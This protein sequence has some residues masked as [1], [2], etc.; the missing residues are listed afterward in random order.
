MFTI[1][2][3]LKGEFDRV[4]AGIG[5]EP[6]VGKGV[7]GIYDVLRAHFLLLDYFGRLGEGFGGVGPRDLN[8][9]HSALSRQLT[10][11]D[12]HDKWKDRLDVCATLFFGLIKNHPFHDGNK[13]TAF[14]VAMYQLKRIGR[15]LRVEASEFERL[16]LRTADDALPAYETFGTFANHRADAPVRFVSDFF[17]RKT[18]DID[19]H[20]YLVTYRQLD[21]LL[22]RYGFYLAHP[23]GNYIHV[24][25]TERR[26]TF[27]GLIPSRRTTEQRV[28][29]VGFPG[30]TREVDPGLV[31]RIRQATDLT[32]EEG[33]DSQV[34]FK[35]AD[36]IE[37]LIGRYHAPLERLADK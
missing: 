14:L 37:G 17:R 25:R 36:D 4:C 31:K 24:V 19:R 21:A 6:Y 20:Q 9:L 34:F 28:M 12:G 27:R 23:D 33:I 16:A 10:S 26:L 11:F 3:E 30:W 22:R 35:G 13:R 8:L 18:R 7:I 32:D 1:A 2:P 29:K 5:P 15:V